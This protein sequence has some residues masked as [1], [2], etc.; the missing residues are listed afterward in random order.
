MDTGTKY[1]RLLRQFREEH[2]AAYGITRM[3]VFGSVARGEQTDGSDI[4]IYVEAD[5]LSLPDLG[6]LLLDLRELL[7][8][9][10]DLVHRHKYLNPDFIRRIE[11][12][13]I[14]V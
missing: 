14:Y 10:V 2:A 12:D 13:M 6:G 5:R 1:F 4:D 8:T 9:N 3:G 11:R 7:G